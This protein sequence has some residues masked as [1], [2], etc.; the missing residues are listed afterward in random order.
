MASLKFL[1][2]LVCDCVLVCVCVCVLVGVCVR[3]CLCVSIIW[4]LQD[5]QVRQL[6]RYLSLSMMIGS[7]RVWEMSRF[8][9]GVAL[10]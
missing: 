6:A 5:C 7:K 8:R 9:V 1:V 2:M 4:V 10:V 3:V